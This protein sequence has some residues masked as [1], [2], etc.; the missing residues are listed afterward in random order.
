MRF[1]TES[2]NF[3]QK[4][5]AYIGAF[6]PEIGVAPGTIGVVR[7]VYTETARVRFDPAASGV[8]N[9]RGVQWR[10][11]YADLVIMEVGDRLYSGLRRVEIGGLDG[12]STTRAIM[13]GD[14][15]WQSI[16]GLITLF[17]PLRRPSVS[18][19]FVE[20]ALY[21]IV[22]DTCGHCHPVNA[23]VKTLGSRH[24]EVIASRM[25]GG[26]RSYDL[27]GGRPNVTW[28]DL[29]PL[30]P[31]CV[32]STASGEEGVVLA[33]VQDYD[34]PDPVLVKGVGWCQIEGMTFVA[35]GPLP[36][37]PEDM[38]RFTHD[39]IDLSTS[40]EVD[41][42]VT[43]TTPIA[44]LA[45]G[46]S[47]GRSVV[48][49]T[50][51]LADGLSAEPIDAET[52]RVTLAGILRDRQVTFGEQRVSLADIPGEEVT[53]KRGPERE[54][55]AT[56]YAGMWRCRRAGHDHYLSVFRRVD[57][58]VAIV[59]NKRNGEAIVHEALP[60]AFSGC[61]L[62]LTVHAEQMFYGHRMEQVEVPVENSTATYGEGITLVRR[63][64]A[65][66]STESA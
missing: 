19:E 8:G 9:Q 56:L 43:F 23:I 45:R 41:V 15:T 63:R 38:A 46:V 48:S 49:L 28:A 58:S 53:V 13:L 33:T 10:I 27:R 50:A 66:P 17:P 5:V 60:E 62:T 21:R 16:G 39:G 29:S 12:A 37:D 59:E 35:D 61:T 7:A 1:S 44:A 51:M 65:T 55:R 36:F 40:E 54:T 20:G 3:T 64:V 2:E 4:V 18:G 57:D 25:S 24:S 11:P 47:M 52:A 22:A 26:A 32:V 42:A 14:S 31:G 30:M 34:E 6:D